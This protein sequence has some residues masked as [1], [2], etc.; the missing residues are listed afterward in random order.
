M[1]P[2]ELRLGLSGRTLLF[3]N[4]RPFCL[5]CGRRP[6][7]TRLVSF[8]DVE[9][10][11]RATSGVNTLLNLVHPAL[12]WANRQRLVTLKI[13]APVCWIHFLRGRGVDLAMTALFVLALATLL[14]LAISG[15]IPRPPGELGAR[16]KAGLVA[17]LILGTWFAWRFR[18]KRAVLPC[19][20]RRESGDLVVLLYPGEAPV[21]PSPPRP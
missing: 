13:D 12:G 10:A 11:D 5:A 6:L 2:R 18:S 4:N 14:V 15:V 3:P 19:Q 17:F 16:L 7:A 8:T 1:G 21:P 20:G 9:F